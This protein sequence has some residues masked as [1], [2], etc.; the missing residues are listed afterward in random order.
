MDPVSIIGIAQGL[1]TLTG[2]DK[3][4]KG[5]IS[6]T[7]GG[8][9]AQQVVQIAQDITGAAEPEDALKSL[10]ANTEQQAAFIEACA[11]RKHELRKLRWEDRK[12][13]RAMYKING[14]MA[15]LIARRVITWNLP[16]IALLVVANVVVA[17]WVE[18]SA[19]AQ[20]LGNVIGFA[21]S[22]LWKE[23]QTVIEFFFGAGL[24][25]NG[26]VDE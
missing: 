8:K 12:D 24:G 4:V 11:K 17:V 10:R 26:D 15:D 25:S 16:F 2:F 7:P 1:A 3:K 19:V 18:D 14:N 22:Q 23:R 21:M 6:S 5:W 20:L 13:A 9:V